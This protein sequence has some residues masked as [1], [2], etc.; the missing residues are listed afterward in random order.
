MINVIQS[1]ISNLLHLVFPHYCEGCGSDN[2]VQNQ[3]LCID[4]LTKLPT[5]G[6]ENI[7]E[8]DVEKM[9][10]GRLPIQ[11]ATAAFYFSKH[12]LIQHLIHQ[13]KYKGNKEAGYFLGSLLGAQ[14]QNSKKFHEIEV[15]IPLPLNAK[16]EAVRGYNQAA[17]IAEGV[18]T[19]FKKPLA[20]KAVART[21]FTET[22]THNN[23]ITRWRNM[24][25]VF[26]VVNENLI[27]NKHVLLVDDIITTGATLESCGKIILDSGCK[28]LSIATVAYAIQ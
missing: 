24:E 22:Q 19:I 6:F 12:T 2:I 27:K 8:N 25:G 9:F 14:L 10:Y 16:K 21:V 13:L 5:T 28:S 7:S 11:Y 17:L 1:H 26:S 15:I 20:T 18:A 23:R 4:C 3:F